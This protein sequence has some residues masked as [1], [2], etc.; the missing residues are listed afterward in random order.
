MNT[1]A[2]EGKHICGN[3]SVSIW[4]SR[5]FFLYRCISQYRRGFLV[6]WVCTNISVVGED[7]GHVFTWDADLYR[8]KPVLQKAGSR[9]EFEEWKER[10]K[11]HKNRKEAEAISASLQQKNSNVPKPNTPATKDTIPQP[12]FQ[13]RFQRLWLKLRQEFGVKFGRTNQST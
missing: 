11:G 7:V 9:K 1:I 12:T 4:N 3:S 13:P 10:E 5:R 6:T 8:P 2:N